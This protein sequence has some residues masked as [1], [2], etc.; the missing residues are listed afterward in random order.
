MN[1]TTFDFG[2]TTRFFSKKYSSETRNK[3]RFT[4]SSTVAYIITQCNQYAVIS[5]HDVFSTSFKIY[6]LCLQ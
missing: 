2:L 4:R 5:V 1:D 6:L 3:E